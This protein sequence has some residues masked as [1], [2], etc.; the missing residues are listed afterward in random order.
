[1][2][3][4][5]TTW[6][7]R[8]TASLWLLLGLVGCASSPSFVG[9]FPATTQLAISPTGGRLLVSWNDASGKL[10]A[11]LIELE[12]A[13]VRSAREL[14]LPAKTWFTRFGVDDDHLLVTT[15]E[16][17][18]GKLLKVVLGTGA[19]E[20]L[21]QSDRNIQFP[22]EIAAGHYAFLEPKD[23][24]NQ[25][26]SQWKQLRNGE[27]QVLNPKSYSLAAHLNVTKGFVYILEPWTPPAFR[28]L[29]GT[30]PAGLYATIDKDTFSIDCADVL[31]MTCVRTALMT[32]PNGYGYRAKLTV[33]NGNRRC[34]ISG[35]WL[36]RREGSI[37][38]DGRI[39]VFHAARA[40]H[41][42]E[43]AL[44]VVKN[45]KTHCVASEVSID[46]API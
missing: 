24:K 7:F 46:W 5:A 34:E 45:D 18:G 31:P 8:F 40:Q 27:V 25:R 28:G 2:R 1:M 41:D 42:G 32:T 12:G 16:D 30:P 21:Y 17:G 23:P 36:D 14:P 44:Y 11:K 10:R 35:A 13:E 9:N 20:L 3:R 38:R 29:Y 37:S 26:F 19:E 4:A 22:M 6:I 43:R 39:Y 15:L 33:L